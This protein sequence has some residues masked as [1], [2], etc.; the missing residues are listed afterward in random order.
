MKEAKEV[1]VEAADV[2]EVEEM[3]VEVEDEVE[4]M[5]VESMGKGGRGRRDAGGGRGR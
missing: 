1:K 5:Q 3:Q 4:E 2:E